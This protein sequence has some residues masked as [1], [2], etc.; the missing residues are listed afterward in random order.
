MTDYGKPK[1]KKKKKSVQI[2]ITHKNLLV[3][4]WPSPAFQA[5]THTPID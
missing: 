2:D 3:H 4:L 5:M 1:K